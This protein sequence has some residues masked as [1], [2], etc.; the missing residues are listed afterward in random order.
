MNG[1]KLLLT[2][3]KNL[4]INKVLGIVG[5]ESEAINFMEIPGME[6]VLTRHE[7]VAGIMAEVGGKLTG[8]PQVLWTS[9]G[10]GV[11]NAATVAVSATQ[12][13]SPLIIIASQVEREYIDYRHTHQCVDQLTMMKPLTKYQGEPTSVNEIPEILNK[14]YVIANTEPKGPVFVSMPVDVLSEN[15]VS[16]EIPKRNNKQF[17]QRKSTF[18]KKDISQ[19]IEVITSARKPIVLVGSEVIRTRSANEF[20]QF[21]EYFKLPML[22]T[23]GGKGVFPERHPL[24]IGTYSRYIPT[25]FDVHEVDEYLSDV[26]LVVAVGYEECEDST[27]SMFDKLFQN[28]NKVRISAIE[29]TNKRLSFSVD[30]VGD[31]CEIFSALSKGSKIKRGMSDVLNI[32]NLFQEKIRKKTLNLHTIF[33]LKVA[34]YVREAIGEMG[35]VTTD[36][37]I[38]R[39][40]TL[41]GT[42]SHRPGTFF[43]S[44]A[45]STFG[46]GLPAAMGAA[47]YNK[48]VPV[49]AVCGDG[50]FHSVIH[51]LETCSRLK[52]PVIVIL[53]KDNSY[54]LIDVYRKRG[55]LK[56]NS[57]MF[58]FGDVNFVKIAKASGCQGIRIRS[59]P[60]FKNA[61]KNALKS[62]MPT[63]IEVPITYAY[64]T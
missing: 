51:D 63:V 34:D 11:T 7:F 23:I 26:D 64:Q 44:P 62:K 39:H 61:L 31:L 60:S 38:H 42:P 30:I 21:T 58:D 22:A 24:S 18:S 59:L 2:T 46:F 28:A 17:T 27:P 55:G 19:V 14:A 52:L 8:S 9:Y 53:F 13:R 37:G 48:N 43:C 35:I 47:I 41:I 56:R 50:G 10:P 15:V 4:G 16:K 40:I 6:F 54:G 1:A 32:N 36:V 45:L 49:I 3:L 20:L 57:V 33:Q 5:R 25:Y 29:N 12:E